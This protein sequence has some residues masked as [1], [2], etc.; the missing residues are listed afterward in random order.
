MNSGTYIFK[1]LCQFLPED[2]FEYLVNKYDGNKYIK[3]FTC[4]NHFLV[5]LWAQLTARE[6]LRDIIGSLNAHRSKFYRLGFGKSVCRTTLSE[7]NEKRNVEIFRLFAER[8]VKIAQDKRGNIEGLFMEG[9]PHRVLALDSTTVTLKWEAYSWSKVQNGKGGIKVHTMFDILTSIPVYNV[10]TDHDVRD[11]S[12]M[13]YFQ[14]EPDAFYIFDKAYVKLLSLNKIDEAGAFFVVRRKEKMN[15]EII[16]EC[17][18][19]VHEKGIL[20]DLKIRLSNRWAKARYQKPLR[21]IYYYNEEKKATLEFFTNNLDLEAHKIAYLYKCRW[22]IEMYFKWIKQHL[23]IKQF[24][25]T[26]ENSVKIQIYVGI[27]AYCL[28]ALVGVELKSK[29]SPFELL[30]ILSV[31]LFEKENL[32][33]FLAKA[34]LSENFQPVSNSNLKL[35]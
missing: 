25:G 8:V 18:C 1:Q 30:R 22:Q 9:I 2:Y 33:E 29:S 21:I 27:I 6:S 10:I 24:Y 31:S 32:K 28:V 11:Q 15:F 19:D 12:V 13:G 23:R 34:E 14:Y 17:S 16:E 7:A 3:S 4:W 35:F 20:R 5:M 26:S